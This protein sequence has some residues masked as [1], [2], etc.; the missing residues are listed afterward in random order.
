MLEKM[1]MVLAAVLTFMMLVLAII[2][3]WML[4][5]DMQRR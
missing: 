3:I 1:L 4:L 5:N 2:F